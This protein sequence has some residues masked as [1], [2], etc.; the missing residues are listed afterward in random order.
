MLTP[1]DT[2]EI[3]K[4]TGAMRAEVLRVEQY[5]EITFAS[6]SLIGAD[7]GF[8]MIGELTIAGRTR[9]VP[10]PVRVAVGWWGCA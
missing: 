5:R 6:K 1:A 2:E 9:E 8:T 4:V 7:G 10:V 3:R